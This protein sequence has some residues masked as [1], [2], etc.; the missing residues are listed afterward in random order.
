MHRFAIES[1]SN[2]ISDFIIKL[3][4]FDLNSVD[5]NGLNCFWYACAAKNIHA[6]QNLMQIKSEDQSKLLIDVT[7]S[8]PTRGTALHVTVDSLFSSAFHD[9]TQALKLNK[10]IDYDAINPQRTELP[11]LSLPNEVNRTRDSDS[12]TPLHIAIYHNSVYFVQLLL[13][14]GADLNTDSESAVMSPAAL[15]LQINHS[16]IVALIVGQPGVDIS[17]YLEK[18]ILGV[19]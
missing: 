15:A 18:L 17:N 6:V 2:R 16:D 11:T 7:C 13:Q 12:F 5:E 19:I 10:L 9:I 4:E 3:P 1:K 8:H 14:L